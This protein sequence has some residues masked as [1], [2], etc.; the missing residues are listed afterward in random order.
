MSDKRPK[1]RVWVATA[2]GRKG[3][4]VARYAAGA[5]SQFL[6]EWQAKLQDAGQHIRGGRDVT[7]TVET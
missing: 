1:K 5:I 6:R 2:Y 3:L 7:T 4:Y